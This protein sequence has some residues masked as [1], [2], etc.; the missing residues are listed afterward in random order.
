MIGTISRRK[1]VEDAQLRARAG[2]STLPVATALRNSQGTHTLEDIEDIDNNENKNKYDEKESTE[3]GEPIDV[4]NIV[5][6]D[7][8]IQLVEN[9][10][11]L[12]DMEKIMKKN[13][14]DTVR[15]IVDNMIPNFMK[16]DQ[17]FSESIV[18]LL[19]ILGDI[20][21]SSAILDNIGNRIPLDVIRQAG[22]V[23]SIRKSMVVPQEQQSVNTNKI[24]KQKKE[25]KN[26]LHWINNV[27]LPYVDKHYCVALYA[28]RKNL[29]ELNKNLKSY[30]DVRDDPQ[31]IDD[32]LKIYEIQRCETIKEN[33]NKL[34]KNIG[35]IKNI[36]DD[37]SKSETDWIQIG[38][39]LFA[40]ILFGCTL[41]FGIGET[42][43]TILQGLLSSLASLSTLDTQSIF[44]LVFDGFLTVLSLVT[45]FISNTMLDV[46]NIPLAAKLLA[47]NQAGLTWVVSGLISLFSATIFAVALSIIKYIIS[48]SSEI[49]Y[50]ML[51][52]PMFWYRFFYV[53]LTSYVSTENKSW[54]LFSKNSDEIMK[55]MFK[56]S[57]TSDIKKLISPELKFG[58][59]R[60][61]FYSNHS[62][63]S[64]NSRMFKFNL[65]LPKDDDPEL[66]KFLAQM[67][68]LP[69]LE[70]QKSQYQ[71]NPKIKKSKKS[72]KSA[73]RSIRK[74]KT[75]SGLKKKS[76]RNKRSVRKNK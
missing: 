32:I 61:A 1:E 75:R 71:F 15:Y 53:F 58:T 14:K 39:G 31:T 8:K 65:H 28:N 34:T 45:T 3:L 52:N 50:K 4:N 49:S 33:L 42:I 67:S 22:V 30:F 70:S 25:E 18:G 27:I 11:G 63:N 44:K 73:K 2:Q 38:S 19:N 16:I 54:D 64:N 46:T 37:K 26:R 7:A 57:M 5:R 43:L 9:K 21:P 47:L 23:F 68:S 69:S 10:I 24:N 36:G 48:I 74:Q 41:G 35:N 51:F 20:L 60:Y 72:K 29:K 66:I 6:M 12:V 76:I 55:S 62:N 40:I 13:G 59:R 56:W 17:K